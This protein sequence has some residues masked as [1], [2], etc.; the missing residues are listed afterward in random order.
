MRFLSI[1]TTFALVGLVGACDGGDDSDTGEAEEPT[2]P[3][4]QQKPDSDGKLVDGKADAWNYTN[5]PARFRLQLE[6]SYETSTQYTEGRAEQV[7]WPSD[8][9]SYYEDSTNVRYHG[10]TLSPTE[11]YD[12]AFHG[13]QA[14][15]DLTPMDVSRD[16]SEGKITDKHDDYYDHLGP[17]AKWQHQNKGNYRARNGRDD[18]D[19]GEIDECGDDYDGIETWWGLCHAWVPAAILTAEPQHSVTINDVEFTTSDIKALLITQH[20]RSSALMLGG[21]CNE[22]EVKRD[23]FGRL[24]QDEC[25]DTN[26]GAFHVVITNML[27]RMKR[28][29]AEDRTGT[30]Q[31]WNQPVLGYRIL[32]QN[33]LTEAEAIKKLGQDIENGKYT[34]LYNSPEAVKWYYVKMDVDY[35]T[36]SSN[37]V[38]GPLA[39]NIQTYTRTDHYEYIV[40]VKENGDIVGGEWINYS[41]E[42]HPD[43][44]WLPTRGRGGNPQID[45]SKVMHLLELSIA[46]PEPDVEEDMKTFG[47]AVNINIPDN[48]AAGVDAVINVEDEMEIASLK[49]KIDIE[50]TWKGDLRLTLKRG[51]VEVVLHDKTGG[52]ADNINE[53]YSVHEF[54]GTPVAGG[55]TLNVSDHAGQDTGAIKHFSLTVASGAVVTPETN[56]YTSSTPVDIPDNNQD[57]V[58]S[59]IS[60]S[61]EGTIRSLKVTLDLKHTYIGDLDINLTHNGQTQVLHNRE[62][63]S[64]DDLRKT[65]TLEGFDGAPLNGE[66]TLTIKDLAKQDV[67]R[68]NSWSIDAS[69]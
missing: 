25:R 7:P 38:E 11:K 14:N 2:P 15:M 61:D 56:T 63:G 28:A 27:G 4:P 20:D 41:R 50:H 52:G 55:W 53:T 3:A 57:G 1:L 18:D 21:R 5:N 23:E 45:T 62:G 26:A 51:D 42:S 68:L 36:E 46:D 58:T 33:E 60:V 48:D 39:G 6:Y 29:F 54:D 17:A 59:S 64:T 43:F 67:G 19:D 16:C 69:L 31:V 40:E 24:T 22:K 37:T 32:E 30:Y 8:Y 10:N 47:G 44:L 12:A 66:W 34:D 9:W 65:F 49:V 13:W 35:I